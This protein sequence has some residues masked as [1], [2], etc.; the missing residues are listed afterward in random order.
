MEI[1]IPISEVTVELLHKTIQ[2][3]PDFENYTVKLLASASGPPL[4][5]MMQ[6]DGMTIFIQ[7]NFNTKRSAQGDVKPKPVLSCLEQPVAP[8][9]SAAAPA[10]TLSI[11]PPKRRKPTPLPTHT[12]T[13]LLRVGHL[14]QDNNQ[15]K[16][17]AIRMQKFNVGSLSWDEERVESITILPTG[18][19]KEGGFRRAKECRMDQGPVVFKPC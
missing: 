5:K 15:V 4:I 6:L 10:V 14:I 18:W 11:M 13:K 7:L 16:P 9:S 12:A 1:K 3:S 8:A 2:E 19:T 17:T